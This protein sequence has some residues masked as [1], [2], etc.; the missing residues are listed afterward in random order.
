MRKALRRRYGI[1]AARVAVRPDVPWYWRL[2]AGLAASA[3]FAA[4]L[5]L[6]AD[7]AGLLGPLHRAAGEISQLEQA[8]AAREAELARLRTGAAQSQI[9]RAASAD[10]AGQVK[11]LAAENAALKE[12]LAFF[13]SVVAGGGG[14]DGT[15]AVSRFRLQPLG[16]GEY[17]YQLVIVQSGERRREFEGRLQFAIDVQHAG[18]KQVLVVPRDAQDDA[19]DY[20]LRFRF[21]QRVEGT[22]TLAPGSTV[23]GMQ[24][25]VYADGE[26]SPRLTRSLALS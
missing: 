24:V 22:F 5:W 3:A 18:A 12:D 25:R 14:A 13:Q 2:V 17:R 23:R 15:L 9:D 21:F 10:L 19:N 1:S 4:V 8:L 26:R 6:A 7:L 20:R 11:A 16:G